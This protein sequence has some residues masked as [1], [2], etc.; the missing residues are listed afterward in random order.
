MAKALW[1]HAVA[2]EFGLPV[3]YKPQREVRELRRLFSPISVM[4]AASRRQER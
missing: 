1:V 4:F 3:V 2:G